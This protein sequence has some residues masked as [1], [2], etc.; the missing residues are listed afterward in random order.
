LDNQNLQAL[1]PLLEQI[2]DNKFVLGDRL[3]EIGVSSPDLEATL[4]AISMAQAE[5][6]H[7]R[8]LYSWV[9]DL[10]GHTGKKPDVPAQTGKAFPTLFTVSNW[11]HLIANVYVVNTSAELVIR[12]LLK[13]SQ[14]EVATR[15]HKLWRELDEHIVY[16]RSWMEQLLRDEGAIPARTEKSLSDAARYAADWLQDVENKTGFADAGLLP[17]DL[18]LVQSFQKQLDQLLLARKDALHAG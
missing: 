10:A 11:I 3:V 14:K 1:I 13:Q 2:A 12:G 9:F 7:A 15:L 17:R 16:A 8:L 5:L 4:G 18:A 6:G